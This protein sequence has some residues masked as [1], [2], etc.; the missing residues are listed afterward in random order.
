MKKITYQEK[1]Y[2]KRKLLKSSAESY[3]AFRQ[4]LISLGGKAAHIALLARETIRRATGCV[5]VVFGAGDLALDSAITV[6][7]QRRA[8]KRVITRTLLARSV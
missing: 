2:G 1:K 4:E 3:K 8:A 6:Q 5:N 7:T